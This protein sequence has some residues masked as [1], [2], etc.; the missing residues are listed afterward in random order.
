MSG[1]INLFD[2][3]N[4]VIRFMNKTLKN[5]L[6]WSNTSEGWTLNIGMVVLNLNWTLIQSYFELVI[7]I[8]ESIIAFLI[9]HF[10]F[11][12]YYIVAVFIVNLHNVSWNVLSLVYDH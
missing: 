1:I 10:V 4:R 7:I 3:I 8:I 2:F 9:L 6:T 5:N 11:K 12:C